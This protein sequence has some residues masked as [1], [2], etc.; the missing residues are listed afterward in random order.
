[1]GRERKFLWKNRYGSNSSSTCTIYV[2][3]F[4]F[5]NDL[6]SEL[7]EYR[8]VRTGGRMA[9]VF[10][11]KK[12]NRNAI[13]NMSEANHITILCE[14]LYI[15]FFDSC[16]DECRRIWRCWSLLWIMNGYQSV[17]GKRCCSGFNGRLKKNDL[18]FFCK[19]MFF[20]GLYSGRRISYFY[21]S[22]MDN[23][24]LGLLL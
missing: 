1:M 24:N 2:I 18:I 6:L 16:R 12:V 14:F 9:F 4:C 10:Y 13:F 8:S 15:T 5:H 17:T 7:V 20:L 22:D 19:R 3:W 23:F 11:K 21:S